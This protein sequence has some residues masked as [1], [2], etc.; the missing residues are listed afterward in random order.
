LNDL[1]KKRTREA[2]QRD[3]LAATDMLRNQITRTH[4]EICEDAKQLNRLR[5]RDKS[6]YELKFEK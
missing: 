2:L 1:E 3:L 6:D 4:V 5:V